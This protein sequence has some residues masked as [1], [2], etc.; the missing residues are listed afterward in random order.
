M[1][2]FAKTIFVSSILVLTSA[3]SNAQGKP[4][5]S[6]K[7]SPSVKTQAAKT[8]PTGYSKPSAAVSFNHNFS[9]RSSLGTTESVT[10][11]ISDRYPGGQLSVDVFPSAGIQMFNNGGL[12]NE[13]LEL[14]GDSVND[15]E[16]RFQAKSE[17]VH[18]ITMVAKVIMPDG[19]AITRSY[20]MPV[21]VGDQ[22]QPVKKSLDHLKKAPTGKV[23]GGLV[24]MDADETITTG[25]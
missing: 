23:G 7:A 22:F 14:N 13:V 10:M 24:I 12:Q 3:C 8:S 20:T 25:N 4:H 21:Y 6:V 1:T 11:K 17:G 18:Q 15:V 19:Q 9:G 2:Y 16:L 5:A